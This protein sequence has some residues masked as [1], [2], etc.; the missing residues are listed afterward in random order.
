MSKTVIIAH[1]RSRTEA[2]V[3]TAVLRANEIPVHVAGELLADE[4][5]ASQ[6]LMGLQAMDIEVPESLAEKARS[7][8]Q[9]ARKAGDK[10]RESSGE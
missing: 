6:R 2:Q 9:A 10:D 5:A 4:F 7:I 8:L 1:A 3:I